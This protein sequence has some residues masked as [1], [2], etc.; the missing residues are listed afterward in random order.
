MTTTRDKLINEILT[1]KDKAISQGFDWPTQDIHEVTDLEIL[2][3][4]LKDGEE[5]FVVEASFEG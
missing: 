1:L 5:F 3:E 4:F 2:K